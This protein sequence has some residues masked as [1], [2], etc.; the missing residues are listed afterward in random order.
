M[1]GHV[2]IAGGLEFKD[3]ATIKRLLCYDYFRGPDSTGFA[4]IKDDGKTSQ[5]AKLA[6]HPFDLFDMGAFK[7]ALSGFHSCVFIGHNRAA[8]RGIV[9]G[10]NA[11]PFES[12]DII[13]AHNGTLTLASLA[14][15]EKALDQEFDVDSEAIVVAIDK[16]GIKKTVSMLQGAW[17]LVWYD[18]SDGSLNFLR[19]KERPFWMA[20]S[21]DCK[22]LF[23][24][25]EYPMIEAACKLS[26]KDQPLY[27]D[28]EGYRFWATV[29]DTHYK[30]D[31]ETLKKGGEKKPLPKIKTLKGK[32]PAPVKTSVI[33]HGNFPKKHGGTAGERSTTK[34]STTKSRSSS[35]RRERDNVVHL[36]GDKE[37]PVAGYINKEELELISYQGCSWCGAAIDV[38]EPGITVFEEIDSILCPKCSGQKS[39]KIPQTRV[40]AKAK[41]FDQ[42]VRN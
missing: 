17:A 29:I 12:G 31:I 15:L 5:I 3:E 6:S 14:E 23:W 35:K 21:E 24:A 36:F 7:K 11:H 13:G 22:K 27:R 25:S 16:L 30:F 28:K 32:E 37:S 26:K 1:C 19:N 41:F 4:A 8:T 40:F 2:G 39:A 42:L 20:Y 18:K 38:E 9:N 10:Y 34:N 33:G